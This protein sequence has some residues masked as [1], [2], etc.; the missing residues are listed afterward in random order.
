M[1]MHLSRCDTPACFSSVFTL[2]RL[3]PRL[4]RVLCVLTFL[5][6]RVWEI[7]FLA[8]FRAVDLDLQ[9]ISAAVAEAA[10]AP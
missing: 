5:L 8:F 1:I 9:D 2:Y 3:L 4:S 7:S 6:L 10:L